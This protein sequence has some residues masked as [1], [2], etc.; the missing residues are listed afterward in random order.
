M[1]NTPTRSDEVDGAFSIHHNVRQ[2]VP[3][4]RRGDDGVQISTPRSRNEVDGAL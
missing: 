3:D 1:N 2:K 4:T